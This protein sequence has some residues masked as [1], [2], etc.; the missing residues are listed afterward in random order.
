MRNYA[1]L[2]VDLAWV[3]VSAFLALLLRDNFSFSVPKL[4]AI[5]PYALISIASAGVIFAAARLQRTVW[6]YTSLLDVLHLLAAVTIALL[7]ALLAAFALNRLDGV[8][9]SVPV[10]QWLLIVGALIGT[11]VAVRV[12]QE[13]GE[14]SWK[15]IDTSTVRQHVLIVGVNNLTELYLSSVAEFAPAQLT[16]VGILS[17]GRGLHGRL[18]RQHR[19]LGSPDDISPILA[20]LE[21]HGVT[22]DQIVVMQPFEQLSKT[23]QQALLQVERSSAIKVK[24]LLETLGWRESLLGAGTALNTVS[25]SAL[26]LPTSLGNYKPLSRRGYAH[27]KRMLD[28]ASG[29][30]LI[31]VLWPALSLV[32]LMVAIDVG[33]PLVFWQQRPG[34]HGRPFKLYKFRTMRAAHDAQGN[35]IPDGL[36]SSSI[37]RFL[38]R[39]RLDELPQL[40]NILVGEMSF[41]GPRPLLAVDQPQERT[42]RLLARPGLTG[43]AQINGGREISSKDK[44]ALD[45]WYVIHASLWLDITILLRTIAIVFS[46]DRVNRLAVNAAHAKLEEMRITPPVE[47]AC[48]ASIKAEP[49]AAGRAA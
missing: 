7:L 23:A 47:A 35:R 6:R 31:L 37:G 42:T 10:I 24:W 49:L 21:L 45:I 11:R 22:V 46:G 25:E 12:L 13:Q 34:R 28:V 19:V 44:A 38:R 48:S 4:Q 40:Y 1:R 29:V 43:W 16:V 8:A 17:S 39:S 36:R 32:A 30:C 15:S 27:A 9:R 41:V 26:R 5:V 14:K 3:A 33:F 2:S 20:E 18:I